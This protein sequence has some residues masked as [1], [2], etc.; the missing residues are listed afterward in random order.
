MKNSEIPVIIQTE[1]IKLEAALKYCNAVPSGGMAKIVIQEELVSVNGE[2]CTLRGKKL[3]PGD[4]V[5]FDGNT[6]CICEYEHS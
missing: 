4:K 2:I 3:Y 5:S 1:Y 6:Y